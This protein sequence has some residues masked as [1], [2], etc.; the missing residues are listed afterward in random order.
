MIQIVKQTTAPENN[1]VVWLDIQEKTIKVFGPNGWESLG[2]DSTGIN[3]LVDKLN[4]SI[5]EIAELNTSEGIDNLKEIKKFL[6]GYGDNTTLNDV[7]DSY[8][9]KEELKDKY[10][11]IEVY[12]Y[13]EGSSVPTS[14]KMSPNYNYGNNGQF[15]IEN[16]TGVSFDIISNGPVAYGIKIK[17]NTDYLATKQYV[18]GIKTSILGSDKLNESYDTLQ[19][20]AE[21]IEGHGDE[22]ATIVEDIN[23]INQNLGELQENVSQV[24]NTL[25]EEI[26]SIGAGRGIKI[27][28]ELP[29][30][31][32]EEDRDKIFFVPREDY[33]D[34][35]YTTQEV[36][37]YARIL[38]TLPLSDDIIAKF[39]D[40]VG[41]ILIVPEGQGHGEDG[42]KN[43]DPLK[44]CIAATTPD[45]IR[46][47]AINGAKSTPEDTLMLVP[48]I[49][50]GSRVELYN[51]SKYQIYKYQDDDWQPLNTKDCLW[52][53]V[54]GNIKMPTC[55]TEGIASVAEGYL[56]KAKGGQSHAEGYN[57][58][59][60]GLASHAEGS[61]NK[62]MGQASHVEGQYNTTNNQAEHASGQYNISVK[63]TFNIVTNLPS[64]PSEATLHSVGNGWGQLDPHNAHEIKFD[65]THL[66][67][68]IYNAPTE[69]DGFVQYWK[70]PMFSLQGKLKEHDDKIAELSNNL[71]LV[72]VPVTEE[73][74]IE[75]QNNH[76]YRVDDTL[77][78]LGIKLPDGEDGKITG[79]IVCFTTGSTPNVHISCG[80]DHPISYFDGFSI[81]ADTTYELNI[82]FNGKRWIVAQ[83]I[84]NNE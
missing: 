61:Y 76:Y 13:T 58:I 49:P 9:T 6:E 23:Q 2:A 15:R 10:G 31:P 74:V 28:D 7:L 1:N 50:E 32:E 60:E 39:Q 22:A 65:G 69:S 75:A 78:Y 33:V 30:V 17:A 62:A 83:G 67:P 80:D 5:E 77:D 18:D 24:Y 84:I 47:Q 48:P 64:K 21:W 42:K 43:D 46:V 55:I 44:L 36:Q 54:N 68:D 66:I 19:E 14:K 79:F 26:D 20:V 71:T 56:T 63:D 82:M 37:G 51:R 11:C 27:V 12:Q 81:E 40:K 3:E 16:G 59:T 57:T 41:T 25:Q 4:K 53:S 29:E 70:A 38:E 35:F 52:E 34:P 45:S 73:T 8:A 72:E